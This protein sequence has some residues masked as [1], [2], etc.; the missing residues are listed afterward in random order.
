[1]WLTMADFPFY[2]LLQRGR[3]AAS[4]YTK[5][6][7]IPM[8]KI[9]AVLFDLDGTLLPMDQDLFVK[10]YFKKLTLKMAPLGYEPEKL[11]QAVWGGISAMV[12]NDGSASNEDVFWNFFGG[13]FGE[14]ALEDIPVF[15][16]FYEVEFQ[17]ARTVCGFN[18]QAAR[19]VRLCRELGLRTVLATNPLFPAVATES[20]MAWAGVSPADFEYYTTYENSVH[21]KP[22][23]DYYRDILAHCSLT[24]QECLMVGNDVDEDMGT[25]DLG[26]QVFLLTDCLINRREADVSLY[27]NGGFRELQEHIRRL[28]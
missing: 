1:M 6:G 16:S 19:S 23:P 17:E 3:R 10:T 4:D 28:V 27:P 25:R 12:Q 8:R 11:I 20:R 15:R 22:N 9:K 14:R 26:M 7:D 24:P 2:T 5:E 13:V 21:C 18:P